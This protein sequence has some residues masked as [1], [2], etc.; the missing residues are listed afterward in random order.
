MEK[1]NNLKIQLN[2]VLPLEIESLGSKGDGIAKYKGFVV[3]VKNARKGHSYNVE[4]TKILPTYAFGD[5]IDE[6]I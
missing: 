1:P 2:D 4:I 6:I 5:V 3:I